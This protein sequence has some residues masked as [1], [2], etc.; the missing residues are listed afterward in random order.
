MINYELAIL[1]AVLGVVYSEIL[2]SPGELLYKVYDFKRFILYKY[3]KNEQ[4]AEYILKPLG[5]CA[6]CTSGQLA[7]WVFLFMGN[8]NIFAHILFISFTILIALI[9]TRT[10]EKWLKD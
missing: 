6:K 4:T 2:T 7:F 9:L 8:Y 3:V 10:I 1:L 5:G